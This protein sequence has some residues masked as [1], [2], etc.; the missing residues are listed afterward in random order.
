MLENGPVFD[1]P[2]KTDMYTYHVPAPPRIIVPPPSLNGHALPEIRL[3]RPNFL[4]RD[5]PDYAGR[6]TSN[7]AL[8]W[9]YEQRRSAQAILPHLHLG[10]MTVVKD[11]AWLRARRITLVLGVRQ[12]G[13]PIMD[14]A[15]AR[16]RETLGL[17]TATVDLASNQELVRAFP[18]LVR[19]MADH[20]VRA[21]RAT[22]ALGNLLVFC[23]SGNDRSAALVAAYLMHT[24][25]DV[26]YIKAMQ[27]CQAQRF[28]VTFDEPLKRCLQSY[29]DIVCAER[30]VAAGGNGRAR[31]AGDDASAPP[32]VSSRSKRGLDK[33]EDEQTAGMDE[34]DMERFNGRA[35]APF[36]DRPLDF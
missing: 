20:V 8:D 2:H 25:H 12:R 17:E 23:E 32:A 14:A 4:P 9:T 13:R 19:A 33:D 36:I 30:V 11:E 18:A 15:L 5:I 34:D 24:H 21:H 1:Y 10:P 28:C 35:F 16:A 3:P 29:W 31:E 27:L 22:G 6:V 26:D 7:A